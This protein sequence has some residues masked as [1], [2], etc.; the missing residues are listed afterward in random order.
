MPI[1]NILLFIFIPSAPYLD[2]YYNSSLISR[3]WEN[4]NGATTNMKPIRVMINNKLNT[5]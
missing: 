1:E 4:A 3:K 2:N 5:C